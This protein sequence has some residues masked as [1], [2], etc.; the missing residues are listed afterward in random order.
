MASANTVLVDVR[1]PEEFATGPLP[2]A[3]NVEYQ[4]IDQLLDQVEIKDDDEVVLYCRSG[5]RSAIAAMTLRSM[6]LKQV[7]DIGGLEEAR[8]TLLRE[9]K[10]PA[11]MHA[12][13]NPSRRKQDSEATTQQSTSGAPLQKSFNTLLEGLKS[14]D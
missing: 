14:L 1:T 12:I 13:A 4:L 3:I 8:E 10:T 6:G 7:R 9:S 5:R 11:A 2:G